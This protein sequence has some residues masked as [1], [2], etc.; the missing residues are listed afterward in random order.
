VLFGVAWAWLGAGETP[1]TS[2]LAGGALVLVALAGN[3]LP[4]L[5]RRRAGPVASA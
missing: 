2:V 3:E 1:A 4:A 5:L